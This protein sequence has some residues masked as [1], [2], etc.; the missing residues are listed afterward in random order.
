MLKKLLFVIGNMFVANP[1]YADT[2]YVYCATEDRKWEWLEVD[3]NYVTVN[4]KWNLA[5][6]YGEKGSRAILFHYF[7]LTDNTILKDLQK[8][9]SDQFGASY[10]Y[11]QPAD[12]K[13]NYWHVFGMDNEHLLNGISTP[14]VAK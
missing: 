12:N 4:G 11:A 14:Y 10:L 6:I 13:A 3:G 2:T 8:K 9:C 1:L 5:W 7:K